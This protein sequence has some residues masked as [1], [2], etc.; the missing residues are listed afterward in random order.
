MEIYTYCRNN[1]WSKYKKNLLLF[2][3][4]NTHTPP[5]IEKIHEAPTQIKI[6]QSSSS[7]QYLLSSQE[8]KKKTKNANNNNN[9]KNNNNNSAYDF[10]FEAIPL[11]L[12]RSEIKPHKWLKYKLQWFDKKIIKKQEKI[13]WS[14]KH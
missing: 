8:N 11:L 2:H 7:T 1:N 9:L 13:I 3:T 12:K 10:I 14:G 6:K 4:H 5:L